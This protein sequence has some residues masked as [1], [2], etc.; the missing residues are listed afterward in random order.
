MTEEKE[1]GNKLCRFICI[2]GI[3]LIAGSILFSA[4]TQERQKKEEAYHILELYSVRM[5]SLLDGLFHKTDI[6]ESVVIINHGQIDDGTFDNLSSSLME[7]EG[8]RAV[9]FLPDGIVSYC[10][11]MEGNESVMGDNIFEMPERRE[12]ALLALRTKEIALSGPYDLTQGGFGLVA[13]NP[14]FLQDENGDETFWGF[15]VV[16]LDLP[17]ALRPL[18]M[19]ELTN[20]GY[21]YQLSCEVNGSQVIVDQSSEE[22]IRNI[23][24]FR[25]K[26][27]GRAGVD[28][29]ETDI[30]VPN[31]TWQLKIVPLN[32]WVNKGQMAFKVAVGISFL[33]LLAE[34]IYLIK[35]QQIQMSQFATTDELT[36]LFNRRRLKEYLDIRCRDENVRFAMFYI[37]LNRFKA[38]NDTMG[39][40]CG[41]AVL[42]EAGHRIKA[43]I[44]KE[45]SVYRIGGDEFIALMELEVSSEN[46]RSMTGI[47][48]KKLKDPFSYENHPVE[49][50]ASIGYAIFPDEERDLDGLLKL[51]DKRMYQEKKTS[52]YE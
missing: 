44:G 36:G 33:L 37:D 9:Q 7:G 40:A 49:I 23:N 29:V 3:L 32:G 1:L 15:S 51:A 38:I 21:G 5:E 8:I 2:A 6:L 4:H 12:D 34:V 17:D 45:G 11:P 10:Y 43:G 52:S 39:H 26:L 20:T 22:D 16:I 50:K 48:K 25:K 46:C 27:A 42:M 35:R 28:Y 41:D 24:Q 14:I 19:W 13:R 47:I 31:H 30:R 18:T